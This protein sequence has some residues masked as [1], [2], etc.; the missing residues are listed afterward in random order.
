MPVYVSPETVVSLIGSGERVFIH[1]SAATPTTLVRAL[2]ARAPEL[3][4]VE[5]VSISVF[6]DFPL[7]A[8]GMEPHFRINSLFVSEPIRQA[9]REGR[10][11]YVPV[12]LSEIPELFRNRVL[13]IDTAIVH[14]SPPDAHGYCSLGVSVDIARS[15]V[16][17]ARK[18]IA[19]VNP[20][21]PRTAGDG[22]I[23][24]DEFDAVVRVEDPLHEAA[25]HAGITDVER[26]IGNHIAELI[27]DGSTL[28]TGI[29]SIPDAVLA[30]LHGHKH[31]G[32]HT[33]MFS[34]GI[35]DLIEK[36]I[37]DN[38]QKTTH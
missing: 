17:E 20:N 18:V 32:I 36:G 14:V 22:M 35:I 34:D 8:P 25:P 4:A 13:P 24:I 3:T 6:G 5:I 7:A 21:M 1:G 15:A 2:A 33:E 29:G 10:A 16:N 12:F 28:Q 19:Q 30:S 9:V 31:L 38:S 23:H 26:R 11:D 27:E 37:I